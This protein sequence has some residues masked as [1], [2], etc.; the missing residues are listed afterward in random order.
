MYREKPRLSG[1]Q[2][3]GSSEEVGG[4]SQFSTSEKQPPSAHV[5]FNSPIPYH[6]FFLLFICGFRVFFR[7]LASLLRSSRV[8]PRSC[9]SGDGFR[10]VGRFFALFNVTGGMVLLLVLV[11]VYVRVGSGFWV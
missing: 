7:E 1:S 3:T 4:R 9:T 11:F 6:L 8:L 10:D 2:R 5:L